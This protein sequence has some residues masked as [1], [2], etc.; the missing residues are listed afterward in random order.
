MKGFR[1]IPAARL[2]NVDQMFEVLDKTDQSQIAIMLLG[3][4]ESSGE[5]G[6]DHPHADQIMVV[7]D[8]AGAVRCR[9]EEHP[10]SAG[11]VV[12][13]PAGAPHQVIGPNR[14]LNFYSPVA[15]PEEG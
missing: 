1:I 4:G 10:L 11:A 13:I 7:L 2:L 14:T 3:E 6:T 8:G 12:V 9:G 15:Y 5:Y